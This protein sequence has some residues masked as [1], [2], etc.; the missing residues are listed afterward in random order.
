M[1]TYAQ[2]ELNVLLPVLV[3]HID[4]HASCTFFFFNDPAT[5]EF[6][7]LPLPDA[8]PISADGAHFGSSGARRSPA[9]TRSLPPHTAPA[10]TGRRTRYTSPRRPRSCSHAA[11]A[12]RSARARRGEIGRAHV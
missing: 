8:L 3:L 9:R 11:G 12:N 1:H 10:R 6:Y 4:S 2:C 7:P 5:T